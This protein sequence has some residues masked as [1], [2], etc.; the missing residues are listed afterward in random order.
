LNHQV[1]QEKKKEIREFL[2]FAVLGVLGELGGKKGF[3]TVS[4]KV[5]KIVSIDFLETFKMFSW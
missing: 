4:K 3:V 2:S 5:P 1:H